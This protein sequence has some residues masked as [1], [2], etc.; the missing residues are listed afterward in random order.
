MTTF[1]H[2]LL[3]PGIFISVVLGLIFVEPDRGTTVLLAAVVGIMLLV[4]GARWRYLIPPLVAAGIGLAY[5]LWHDPVRIGRILSWLDQEAH[6]EGVGFQGWQARIALGAGG[7]SGLGLG[8]GRQKLG[9]VPEHQ[10]DFI[11]S[12]IGEELGVIATLSIV[13]L[14]ILLVICGV[15]IAEFEDTF[16]MMPDRA[17]PSSSDCRLISIRWC[18]G[19]LP[20]KGLPLPFISYGDPTCC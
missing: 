18:F 19:V 14:F 5:S 20:N 11:L 10:T 6:K 1:K 9:F 13:L 7:W 3:V 4:A 17:S 8:N 2:G 15:Y 16:G 12:V